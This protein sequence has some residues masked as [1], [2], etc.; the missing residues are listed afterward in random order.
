VQNSNVSLFLQHV[1]NAGGDNYK[2]GPCI[3]SCQC[4]LSGEGDEVLQEFG[5]GER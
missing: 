5:A 4:L 3:T 2:F 1:Y